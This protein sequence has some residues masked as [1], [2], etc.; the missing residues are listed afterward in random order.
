M[1]EAQEQ[2]K[3]TPK[4]FKELEGNLLDERSSRWMYETLAGLDRQ[5]DRAM[6]FRKLAEFEAEHAIRW[7]KLMGK[8]NHPLPHAERLLEHRLLVFLARIFGVGPVVSIIHKGE[9]DGIAKYKGQ[10]MRWKDT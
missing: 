5:V 1:E 9:V 2:C 3:W 4:D 6:L 7:E 10:A 8:L